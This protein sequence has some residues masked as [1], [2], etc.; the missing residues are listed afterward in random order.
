MSNMM[1]GIS[2]GGTPGQPASDAPFLLNQTLVRTAAGWRIANVLPI[3]L[4]APSGAL[5]K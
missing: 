3:P 2:L 5:P 1:S 4:P